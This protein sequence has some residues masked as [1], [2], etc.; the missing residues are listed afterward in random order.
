MGTASSAVDSPHPCGS[1]CGQPTAVQH[2][3]RQCCQFCPR[4]PF[5]FLPSVLIQN[6]QSLDRNCLACQ[7]G[8]GQQFDVNPGIVGRMSTHRSSTHAVLLWSLFALFLFRV[9]AQLIQYVTPVGSLPP[10]GRWQGS[11]LSYPVLLG[12]QL[13]IL[14]VMGWGAVGIG[15]GGVRV[16]RATGAWLLALGSLYFLSMGV[17]LILGLTLLANSAWFAKTL[18]A[19]FHMVLA[20]FI[21]VAGHFHWTRSEQ[22]D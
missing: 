13:V 7:S 3:S 5:F 21:L 19:F 8:V 9:L 16:R 6:P 2:C 22:G 4:P 10:F 17:R 15:R 12:S 14:A 1:P 20:T 11:G 18:P